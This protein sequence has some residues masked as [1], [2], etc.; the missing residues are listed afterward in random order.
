MSQPAHSKYYPLSFFAARGE[1]VQESD[2][3]SYFNMAEVCLILI[4]NLLNWIPSQAKKSLHN[5]ISSTQ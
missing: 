1:D 4:Q 3:T 2:S 5:S